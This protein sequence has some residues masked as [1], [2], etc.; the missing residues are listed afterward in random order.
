LDPKNIAL[1]AQTQKQNILGPT[2][3]TVS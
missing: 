1:R 3:W 2:R